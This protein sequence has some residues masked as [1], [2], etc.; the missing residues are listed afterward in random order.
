MA[1]LSLRAAVLSC[2]CG[3][4][5]FSKDPPTPLIRKP[6]ASSRRLEFAPLGPSHRLS[7]SAEIPGERE[8]R[9][10]FGVRLRSCSPS[11]QRYLFKDQR[12][13]AHVAANVAPG[14][15]DLRATWVLVLTHFSSGIARRPS[16]IWYTG[17]V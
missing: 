17:I 1:P 10:N 12:L 15:K 13:F 14:T 3:C 4:C 7:M 8:G 5:W 16:K 6:Q 9:Q 11:N 2:G